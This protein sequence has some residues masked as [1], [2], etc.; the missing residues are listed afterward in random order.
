MSDY[1]TLEEVIETIV[2]DQAHYKS[3]EGM[4]DDEVDDIPE[5]GDIWVIDTDDEYHGIVIGHPD[6]TYA[7]IRHGEALYPDKTV[8][9]Y[10]SPEELWDI[11]EELLPEHVL[12]LLD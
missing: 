5:E 10:D 2:D 1:P 7:V 4:D 12:N 9:R 3:V 11:L 8:R 6:E